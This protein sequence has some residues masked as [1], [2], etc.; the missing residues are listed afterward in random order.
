M[1]I[2]ECKTTPLKQKKHDKG[3]IRVLSGYLTVQKV[4]TNKE[5]LKQTDWLKTL[6]LVKFDMY[7]NNNYNGMYNLYV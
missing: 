1:N 7:N 4:L 6:V 2:E 3:R 5:V